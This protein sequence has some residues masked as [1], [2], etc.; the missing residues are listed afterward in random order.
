MSNIITN[1]VIAKMTSSPPN[2]DASQPSINSN[3]I[4]TKGGK[5]K[6]K[7]KKRI[8]VGGTDIA[9]SNTPHNVVSSGVSDMYKQLN[10]AVITNLV[11]SKTDGGRRRPKRR[12]RRKRRKTRRTRRRSI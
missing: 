5:R 1:P 11:E 2:G 7:S 10:E 3:K 6:I 9:V 8:L 12:T 4:I